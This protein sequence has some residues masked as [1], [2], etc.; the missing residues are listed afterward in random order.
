MET[1][2]SVVTWRCPKLIVK[3]ANQLLL[4]A[5]PQRKVLLITPD[6]AVDGEV[7]FVRKSYQAE[8][9]DDVLERVAERL[10]PKGRSEQGTCS[11]SQKEAGSGI[12][13]V[14]GSW[15]AARGN[16]RANAF[17]FYGVKYASTDQKRRA[18]SG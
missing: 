7:H 18:S 8:E 15:A 4:Q 1:H 10:P 5:D 16:S 11:S 12:R 13:C 3:I 14:C 17:P 2:R 9:F 6:N